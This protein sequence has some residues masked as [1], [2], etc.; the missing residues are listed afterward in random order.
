[1][2]CKRFSVRDS[3]IMTEQRDLAKCK[4]CDQKGHIDEA[5]GGGCYW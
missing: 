4:Q 2:L 5:L 3:W 1:M